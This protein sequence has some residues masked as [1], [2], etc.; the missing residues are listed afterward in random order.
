MKK[1]KDNAEIIAKPPVIY[2]AP[3]LIGIL[4]NKFFSLKIFSEGASASLLILSW[5]LVVFGFFLAGWIIL[6]FLKKG[7]DI[8]PDKPTNIIITNGPFRFSRN[9]VYLSLNIVYIG[10]SLILNNLWLI[11]FWPLAFLILRYGVI[12]KEEQYLERKFGKKY[13]VYK[14]RT[15]RWF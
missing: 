6:I 13:L 15:R 9:P 2:G 8:R 5:I 12:S 3:F 10:L 4:L 11:I 7:E 14:K 1:Q